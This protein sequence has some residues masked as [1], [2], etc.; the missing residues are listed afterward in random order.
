MV[1]WFAKMHRRNQ[2]SW[3]AIV[4]RMS[5]EGEAASRTSS[6]GSGEALGALWSGQARAAF[7][8][9]G[10]LMEM[11]DYAERNAWPDAARMQAVRVAAVQ[12]RMAAAK[13][14]IRRRML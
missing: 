14:M 6:P 7:R 4:G 1:D 8:D 12:M 13:A 2:R 3:Q 11:A 10:V 5:S 9:A